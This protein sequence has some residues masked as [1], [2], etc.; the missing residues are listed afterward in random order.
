MKRPEFNPEAE[1]IIQ[2]AQGALYKAFAAAFP[3][4]RDWGKLV[5]VT[6][7]HALL[8]DGIAMRCIALFADDPEKIASGIGAIIDDR[9]TEGYFDSDVTTEE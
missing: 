6:V 8:D 2:D 4:N 5:V 1:K 9:E 7:S 3:N